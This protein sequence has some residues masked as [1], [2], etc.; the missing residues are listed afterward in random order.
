MTGQWR[1]HHAL[2]DDDEGEDGGLPGGNH[3][4]EAVAKADL[5]RRMIVERSHTEQL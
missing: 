4:D 3:T 5:K 1:P 2:N